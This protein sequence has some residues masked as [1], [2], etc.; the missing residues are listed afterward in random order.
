MGLP[1]MTPQQYQDARDLV[2]IAESRFEK[3]L[4][5]KADQ[6]SIRQSEDAVRLAKL[7]LDTLVKNATPDERRAVTLDLTKEGSSSEWAVIDE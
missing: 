7:A 6:A 2:I 5:E 3:L 4:K 1:P